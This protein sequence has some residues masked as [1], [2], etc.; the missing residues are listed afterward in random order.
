MGWEQT[1]RVQEFGRLHGER[2]VQGFVEIRSS[3]TLQI[4]NVCA[5]SSTDWG[6]IH[7]D[8]PW[9]GGMVSVVLTHHH[10]LRWFQLCWGCCPQPRGRQ[11]FHLLGYGFCESEWWVGPCAVVLVCV[12]VDSTASR[13]HTRK[14]SPLCC[15]RLDTATIDCVNTE[16]MQF[17]VE[18]YL[19]C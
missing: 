13:K 15:T 17:V 9:R 4:L 19:V 11:Q 3:G 1:Q 10:S 6:Q 8:S 12:R 14:A 5:M 2:K 18:S 7:L 16:C